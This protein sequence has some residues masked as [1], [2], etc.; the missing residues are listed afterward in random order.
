M[1]KGSEKKT[2][3]SRL[4]VNILVEGPEKRKRKKN[5][6]YRSIMCDLAGRAA[7]AKS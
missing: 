4:Y 5:D 1:V 6:I 3:I 7:I 2:D